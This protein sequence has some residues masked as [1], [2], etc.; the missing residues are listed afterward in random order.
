VAAKLLSIYTISL[1]GTGTD[2]EVS[3]TVIY[4]TQKKQNVVL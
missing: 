4:F 2:L 3:T 1:G